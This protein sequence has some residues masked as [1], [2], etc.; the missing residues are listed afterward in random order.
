M[1]ATTWSNGNHHFM[2]MVIMDLKSTII[3]W[4]IW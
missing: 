3:T 1:N 4:A 2:E